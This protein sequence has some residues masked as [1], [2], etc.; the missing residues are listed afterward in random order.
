MISLSIVIPTKDRKDDLL[1]CIESISKQTVRPEEVLVI[2]DGNISEATKEIIRH[3]LDSITFKYFKKEIPSLSESKNLGVKESS[4]QVILF[5][6][7]DIIL[8]NNY[9]KNILEIWEKKWNDE[10]LAGISGVITNVA[11]KSLSKILFEKIF[12]SYYTRSWSIL[13]WGFHTQDFNLKNNEIADWAPG[14]TTSYRKKIFDN[15]KF[16]PLQPGRTGIEDIEFCWQIKDKGYYFIITPF[17]K[18]VHRE[19][20][21]GRESFFVS[22]FKEM[23][24]RKIIFKIHAKKSIENYVCLYISLFG[25]ILACF[26]S[27]RLKKGFGMISGSIFG[28][29]YNIVSNISEVTFF[30]PNLNSGG[31]E[32]A[33]IN[34]LKYLKNSSY[35]ISLLLAKKEGILLSEVPEDVRVFELSTLSFPIIFVKLVR[36]FNKKKPALFISTFP[37]LSI[38]AILARKFSRNKPKIIIIEHSVFSANKLNARTLLRRFLAKFIFPSLMRYFYREVEYI[39]CVSNGVANDIAEITGLKNNIKVIYNP[40]IVKEIDRLSQEKVPL[41]DSDSNPII[42]AVGRLVKAKDYPTLLEAFSLVCKQINAKLLI[43]GEGEERE[44]IIDLAKKLSVGDNIKLLGFQKNP[45]KYMSKSSVFVLSSIQ[46]GFPTVILEAMACGAPV[47]STNCNSGPNEIIDNNKN[48]ILVPIKN[49]QA[50]ADALLKI[51]KDKSFKEYI[52]EGGRNRVKDF[53]EKIIIN[54]YDKIIMS[55]LK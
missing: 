22:G 34:L 55:C 4:G 18:V 31:A 12:F 32:R 1:K 49:P 17:S 7:D 51:L 43:L 46:E 14:G 52:I 3:R 6:D 33:A 50:M 20:L 2:D 28:K 25:C 38:L 13:P 29:S 24:N 23:L 16:R 30:L 47:V 27:R 45:Y 48:G 40:I 10:K 41:F 5:L 11:K 19:S 36:Y 54:E 37:S 21:A 42:L 8:D 9:T 53:S 39:I 15:Y 26:F 44:K 35:K